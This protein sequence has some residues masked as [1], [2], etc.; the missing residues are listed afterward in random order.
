[1]IS[2]VA[3]IN[4][5]TQFFPVYRH[6]LFLEAILLHES[7]LLRSASLKL[8]HISRFANKGRCSLHAISAFAEL[9]Y[10]QQ[11]RWFSSDLQCLMVGGAPMWAAIHGVRR[12]EAA[13]SGRLERG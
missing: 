6:R 13:C 2:P 9:L 11:T 8:P 10:F 12:R 1:M 7:M 4:F 3:S 5:T